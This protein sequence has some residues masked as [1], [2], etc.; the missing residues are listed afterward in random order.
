[1][2]QKTKFLC[3]E[4]NVKTTRKHPILE[5][6]LCAACQKSKPN[7][8]GYIT[9]TRAMEDFRLK[10]RDLEKLR[11]HL[12]DNPHY[13]T[14]AP[15]QLY[16]TTQITSLAKEKWGSPEPYIVSLID[17]SPN[18]FAWLEQDFERIKQLTPEKF[19]FLIADRL[20]NMGFGIEMVGK[21]NQRDG[22]IDII[23]WPN[24]GCTFPFLLAVQVK[25]H[26]T[27]Q[28]TKVSYVR[29]L[30]GVISSKASPFNMGMIVT[31][32]SFTPD[33]KWFGDN[34]QSLLRLR[35]LK[36]LK[37]WI[38]ND[39]INEHEW[40]EIPDQIEV[41]PGR[42]ILLP[43]TAIFRPNTNIFSSTN[44]GQL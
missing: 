39:F 31:N 30:H 29:D 24:T 2:P 44:G 36:D 43:K 26:R 33:A 6:P 37:R 17:F 9:K 28:N 40:R 3:I 25:H 7:K 5:V 38:K 16:L 35:D 41:A 20:D 32:T 13:K 14:A 18:F 21:T 10:P 23:A 12:V 15:M 19:E 42:V 11:V 1:M 27:Q 8:Y 22:G 4:C 34:N